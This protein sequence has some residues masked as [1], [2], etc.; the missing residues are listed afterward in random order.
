MAVSLSYHVVTRPNGVKF[1]LFVG[2]LAV[3]LLLPWLG[4]PIVLVL[5]LAI[6]GRCAYELYGS[7]RLPSPAFRTA[8]CSA[9]ML[10]GIAFLCFAIVLPLKSI[11]YAC[12]VALAVG[13]RGYGLPRLGLA[14]GA[15]AAALL[16][17][18]MQAGTGLASAI[19]NGIPITAAA[20]AGAL[21]ASW[22]KRRSGIKGFGR[23]GHAGVLDYFDSFLFVA[24]VALAVMGR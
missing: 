10:L 14:G 23:S 22:V 17:I 8:I 7:L 24:P 11:S 16:A 1:T 19:E 12:I 18:I 6:L 20:L 5:T 15:A 21:A 2:V 4:R 3:V 13:L 9:Y